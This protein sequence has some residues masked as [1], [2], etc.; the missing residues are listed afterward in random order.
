[1][2]LYFM[3]QKAIDYMKANIR[4]IYM[5]YYR[6]NTNE[7]IYDLFD[8]DPFEFFI[9][10]PDFELANIEGAIGS[11]ELENCK[12]IYSHLKNISASQASDERLW[13]GLCNGVFYQY[14][15]KRWKYGSTQLKKVETDS[16]AIL[17]RFFFSGGTRA[18]LYRNTLSKCWWVGYLTY[19]N[20]AYNKWE[21][22][23]ALGPNDF[24]TKVSDI[25]YSNNFSANSD[26]LEG[27]CNSIKFFEERD[28]KLSVAEHIRPTLQYLNAIGGATLLDMYSSDEIKSIVIENIR[29]IQSGVQGDLIDAEENDVEENFE[30]EPKGLASEIDIDYQEF[31]ESI[32]KETELVDV[33]S[34]L[35]KLEEIKHG[36]TVI[37]HMM[38]KNKRMIY[39]IPLKNDS[40]ELYEIE[41]KMLGKCVGDI[42]RVGMNTFKVEEIHW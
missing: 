39:K 25:F 38:P 3:K 12:I 28:I 26:I 17:S 29:R 14:V 6:Y 37:T 33:N 2:R 32:E 36:C 18:G 31:V 27:I 19:N 7:W 16:S 34:V 15:R 10:I 11:V 41:R 35:D 23:D 42:I 13:A 9:D 21:L 22:L 40:R 30:I 24:A 5:N 8:Y 4:N 20:A 1:M